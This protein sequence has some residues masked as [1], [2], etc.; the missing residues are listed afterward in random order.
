VIFVYGCLALLAALTILF[1][2]LVLKVAQARRASKKPNCY[3]CGSEALH[4]STPSGLTGQCLPE[5]N[6]INAGCWDKCL[7]IFA[8]LCHR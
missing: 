3:Y 7:D 1:S 8:R 4:V 2:V 5:A 6:S